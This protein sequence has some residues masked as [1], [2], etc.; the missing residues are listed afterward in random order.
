MFT[1]PIADLLTRI[2][3]A[4]RAR[5]FIV[6]V[7]ASNMKLGIV[8][9]LHDQGYVTSYKKV[10]DESGHPVI[11]IA[12]KYDRLTKEPAIS[13]LIRVS[14]P[15]LRQ[16]RGATEVPRVMNGL[17]TAIMSTSRGIITGKKAK[18]LNVGG[19]LLCF[20]Y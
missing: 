6:D 11:K 10:V 1:D 7:P 15:G 5:K 17:G 18:E 13:H 2:R 4:S 3:N 19:E 9:V 12:L 8:Q 20:V 16:Y 14:K